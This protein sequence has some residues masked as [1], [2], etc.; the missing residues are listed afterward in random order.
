MSPAGG[1]PELGSMVMRL[2]IFRACGR[3]LTRRVVGF[4]P[5]S[6]TL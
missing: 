6:R 4:D 2:G 1:A 3:I 5:Y